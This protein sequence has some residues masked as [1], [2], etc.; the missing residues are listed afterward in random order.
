MIVARPALVRVLPGQDQ[1]PAGTPLSCTG[2]ILGNR[3][4]APGRIRAPWRGPVAP[5]AIKP[6]GRAT[7][8][9]KADRA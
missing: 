9:G 7:S 5:A 2:P 6:R 3:A 8:W 1:A 4:M